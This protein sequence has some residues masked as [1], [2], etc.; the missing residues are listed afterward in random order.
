MLT[1]WLLILSGN[2]VILGTRQNLTR[3]SEDA[4]KDSK[5]SWIWERATIARFLEEN[6]ILIRIYPSGSYLRKIIL[7]RFYRR[8]RW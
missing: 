5:I 8:Y 4:M 1:I 3:K 7:G 6:A 2:M